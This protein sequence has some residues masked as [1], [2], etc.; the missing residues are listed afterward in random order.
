MNHKK[1]AA[2]PASP[3][4][5]GFATSVWLN[6]IAAVRNADEDR[7]ETLISFNGGRDAFQVP[8]AMDH[9]LGSLLDPNLSPSG[10]G[11]LGRTR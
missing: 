7:T 9:L 4:S 5:M 8:F 6:S 3:I 1:P 2:S 10:H 11:G